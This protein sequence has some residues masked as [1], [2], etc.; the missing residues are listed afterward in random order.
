M[1]AQLE[2]ELAL[3]PAA[4]ASPACTKEQTATASSPG[5]LEPAEGEPALAAH[6]STTVLQP[7]TATAET[8]AVQGWEQDVEAGQDE[9]GPAAAPAAGIHSH[10]AAQPGMDA[11]REAAWNAALTPAE[12]GQ[13]ASS[14]AAE[15]QAGAEHQ[16]APL[17]GN[18][19]REPSRLKE[20][21]LHEH[22][23]L[24]AERHAAAILPAGRL[25][26]TD[27][28]LEAAAEDT[29]TPPAKLAT[30]P[31]VEPAE[32][33]AAADPAPAAEPE[34][35]EESSAATEEAEEA[36]QL[37]DELVTATDEAQPDVAIEPGAAAELE[38]AYGEAGQQLEA[39]DGEAR[40]EHELLA[41]CSSPAP[42]L[43]S[44]G[45]PGGSEDAA[46]ADAYNQAL[47]LELSAKLLAVLSE[48]QLQGQQQGRQA[49]DSFDLQALC[50]GGEE[51]RGLCACTLP[52]PGQPPEQALLAPQPD[53]LAPGGTLSQSPGAAAALLRW[54]PAPPRRGSPNTGRAAAPAVHSS[55]TAVASPAATA[56]MGPS[57]PTQRRRMAPLPAHS[58][59]AIARAAGASPPLGKSASAGRALP[60]SGASSGE[61]VTVSCC[62]PERCIVC[63]PYRNTCSLLHLYTTNGRPG[64]YS[65]VF[66]GVHRTLA[67]PAG[68]PRRLSK[69]SMHEILRAP[70][71]GG[72]RSVSH[73]NAG[74]AGSRHPPGSLPTAQL[75][76]GRAPYQLSGGA[77][78]PGPFPVMGGAHPDA[79]LH[80]G[81]H[82]AA[83]VAP[84][85]PLAGPAGW[86]VPAAVPAA[87]QGGYL[88][89]PG[90]MGPPPDSY[91]PYGQPG[92]VAGAAGA[93]AEAAYGDCSSGGAAWAKASPGVD[94]TCASA[95]GC[96]AAEQQAEGQRVEHGHDPGFAA[97]A[98]TGET[99]GQAAADGVLQPAEDAPRQEQYAVPASWQPF[100]GA[101]LPPLRQVRTGGAWR[102]WQPGHAEQHRRDPLR[103]HLRQALA[104]CGAIPTLSLGP[105]SHLSRRQASSSV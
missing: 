8:A 81:V 22:Q 93:S 83:P 52:E 75:L 13:L 15:E 45:Q 102:K 10:A 43:S 51:S 44:D 37:E 58:P 23:E 63:L 27:A 89:Q 34:L 101:K 50:E 80:W 57:G 104:G 40:Q 64:P 29:V 66:A 74:G 38:A 100:D 54:N 35:Q 30:R 61:Q 78:V 86:F 84:A 55:Q 5:A 3:D 26:V 94:C 76:A 2:Q 68:R 32:V 25:A 73:S 96:S 18:T 99:G 85:M 47:N 71:Q 49:A 95:D 20:A 91:E 67:G 28:P 14:A 19:S 79:M 1:G 41:D 69:P 46:A 82:P 70:G 97:I 56:G 88:V 48:Q 59:T 11:E 33:E 12:H 105:S 39:A 21:L 24:A 72:P 65:P 17:T 90:M 36:A 6:A 53:E 31:A 42:A 98:F 103:P 9:D 77:M 87:G 4:T 92:E 60:A 62:L 7:E 16:E